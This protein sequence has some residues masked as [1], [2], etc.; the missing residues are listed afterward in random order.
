MA[1]L[2]YSAPGVY[3]EEVQRG[4]GSIPGI[5]MSVA[6]FVGFTEDVRG[7]AHLFEPTLVTS[8]N[9]YLQYFSKMGSD[10][11]TEFGSY[12]P[13]SVKGWF[14]N[15]GGRCWVVSLGS[16]L[17]S[18]NTENLPNPEDSPLEITTFGK[19]P[20]LQF[21]LKQEEADN[22]RISVVVEPDTPRLPESPDEEPPFDT[23]EFFKVTLAR[24]EKVLSETRTEDGQ[25]LSQTDAV[26]RHLTMDRQ[27]AP[28]VGTYVET[29][30]RESR[31]VN[32]SVLSERGMPLSR[33][34]A[35]GAYEISPP[36]VHY[37]VERLPY[38]IYG[39]QDE[40]TGVQ[41]L[42]EIDDVSIISCPDIM[43][44]FQQGM[45]GIDQV[46]GLMEMLITR[47]ENSAP[48]PA[49]KMVVLDPPPVRI[50]QDND[51]PIEPERCRPQ[52]VAKWLDMFGRRSQFAALY[53]PWIKVPDIRRGGQ[54]ITVPP[55]G[56]L[57]G[58]WARI[59]ET[60]GIHKA[61]ANE[62]PRGVTGLA[63]DTNFR[64]QEYLNPL[65]INCIRKFPNRGLQV[66]G[67]RTLVEPT[68]TDW[69]Y[70]SVRRIMSYIAKSI[71]LGTQW[72]VFEPNDVHLWAKVRRT[73]SNFL[74][75]LWRDGALFGNTQKEAFFVKCDAEINTPE[76]M[77]LGRLYVEIGVSPVRPAVFVIF[78]ISQYVND[79]ESEN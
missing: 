40:R 71:E 54:P 30:L 21:T 69:R 64:E 11:Y 6:G 52:D 26:Y 3:V 2:D 4:G 36:L 7:G 9:Q 49:Y 46:N 62:V 20:T 79:Y 16:E 70:I 34:P 22:G 58:I 74:E 29:A 63:Y 15:G 41:G 51:A 17:P 76:T 68:D 67:A 73:I 14:D 61:P 35:D 28:E 53:Y 27:V 60:R 57:M 13:Y 56:H 78:R 55:S 72:A 59:D 8:W 24:R 23:G 10:G 37:T 65:G 5:S 77:K 32:L 66:W 39:K 50:G 47:C 18:R 31:Y 75:R 42:F 12:L 1:R 25:E 19:A 44:A 43:F 45:L 38:Q 33:R 48:S